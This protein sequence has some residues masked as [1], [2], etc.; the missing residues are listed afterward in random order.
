MPESG[1][2]APFGKVT[3]VSRKHGAVEPSAGE[4]QAGLAV[5]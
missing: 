2:T 1:S 3:E 4:R 5:T